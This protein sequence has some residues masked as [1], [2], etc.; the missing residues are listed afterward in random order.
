MGQNPAAILNSLLSEADF[1]VDEKDLQTFVGAALAALFFCLP[2][3]HDRLLAPLSAR[4]VLPGVVF[5]RFRL[6]APVFHYVMPGV[7]WGTQQVLPV[8]AM[9]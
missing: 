6:Q 7:H 4:P 8:I 2:R 3:M 5:R 1:F 9:P